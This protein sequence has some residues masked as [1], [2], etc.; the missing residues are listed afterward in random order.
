V[1]PEDN[2]GSELTFYRGRTAMYALLRALK[3]GA[4]NEVI[5]QAYTCLAVP[6]PILALGAKPV[7]ADV[8]PRTYSAHPEKIRTLITQRT[9]AIVVQHTFGIPVRLV[10]LFE[11]SC[12]MDLRFLL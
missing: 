3:V 7:Y 2:H 8:D 4:G 9:R 6:L 10:L 11:I 1:N 5:V 12:D